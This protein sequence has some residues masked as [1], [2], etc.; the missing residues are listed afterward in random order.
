MKA[1]RT[2]VVPLTIALA[3]SMA[4]LFGLFIAVLGA[5]Y[6]GTRVSCLVSQLDE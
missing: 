6:V 4:A 1:A 5:V 3:K 2:T